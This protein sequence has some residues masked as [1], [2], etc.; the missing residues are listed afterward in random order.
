MKPEERLYIEAGRFMAE[1]GLLEIP[2]MILAYG[3]FMQF[4]DMFFLYVKHQVA[5]NLSG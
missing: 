2:D 4:N 3:R 5:T 1:M